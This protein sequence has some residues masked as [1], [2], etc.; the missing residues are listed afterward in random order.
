VSIGKGL[1]EVSDTS[2]PSGI[3]DIARQHVTTVHDLQVTK[4]RDIV[5]LLEW[6][7]YRGITD[8]FNSYRLA[9]GLGF[10]EDPG[11]RYHVFYLGDRH[12]SDR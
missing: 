9:P 11:L 12:L 8:L 7:N 6:G 4:C 1:D 3:P 10:G 5:S 2:L